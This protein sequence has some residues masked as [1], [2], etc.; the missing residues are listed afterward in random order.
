MAKLLN[1]GGNVKLDKKA[2][3]IGFILRRIIC[4][5]FGDEDSED[6]VYLLPTGE[7][8]WASGNTVREKPSSIK[9]LM[10]E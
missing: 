3:Y 2:S 8:C 1:E 4:T 5:R 6:F 7:R 10:E 9:I